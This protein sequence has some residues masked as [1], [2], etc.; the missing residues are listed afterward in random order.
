MNVEKKIVLQKSIIIDNN[1]IRNIDLNDITK[2]AK[3]ISCIVSKDG[4]N[5]FRF[6][7]TVDGK[8]KTLY[9][10][11]ADK[12]DKSEYFKALSFA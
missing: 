9:Y 5:H 1:Y 12:H 4:K 6:V 8:S 7:K 11:L 3:Y 2:G 10:K